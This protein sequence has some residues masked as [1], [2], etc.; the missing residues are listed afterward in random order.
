[1]TLAMLHEACAEGDLEK[2][3]QLVPGVED[4]NIRNERGW[5]ALIMAAF[6]QHL[7][8]VR[9]LIEIAG[10]DVNATNPKGTTVFMYAKT[11]VIESHE[12][13]FLEYLI[14]QGADINAVDQHGKTV[15][16]YVEENEKGARLTG[17]LKQQGCQ[18]SGSR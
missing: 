9:F 12:T 4:I 1:M 17:W 16:D 11:A 6:N 2:V 13:E 8:V 14:E 10:A 5:N 15:L 18:N 7:N 3:K